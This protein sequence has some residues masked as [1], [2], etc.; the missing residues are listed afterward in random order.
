MHIRPS[1]LLLMM[2]IL[3]F[4]PTIQN[5]IVNG[6]SQWYRPHLIWLLVILYSFFSQRRH[7]GD[8]F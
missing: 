5:W 6:G 8:K 2:L 1:H 4:A 3:I 7:H